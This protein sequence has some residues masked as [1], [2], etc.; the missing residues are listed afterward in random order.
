MTF[1]ACWKELKRDGWTSKPPVGLSN[2]FFYI[3]PGKTKKGLRGED[4]F[5]G[6]KELMA[7]LDRLALDQMRQEQKS[8]DGYVHP[9]HAQPRRGRIQRYK[10]KYLYNT[11][12]ASDVIVYAIER[13]AVPYEAAIEAGT[14]SPE[15]LATPDHT[16]P[17][18]SLIPTSPHIMA[19][20]ED[21]DRSSQN[22]TALP[23]DTEGT[24]LK[25][26]D[27]QTNV[28]LEYSSSAQSGGGLRRC[29]LLWK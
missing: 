23:D 14:N 15:D 20:D 8:R 16:T 2:D 21:S 28:L 24:F 12:Y 26:K 19:S 27:P 5:I 18:E 25:Q 10:L 11:R 13:I 17:S 9:E 6:E 4:F 22:T 7:Y 29:C 3:K 1:K